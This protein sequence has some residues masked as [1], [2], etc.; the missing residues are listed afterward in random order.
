MA[1]SNSRRAPSTLLSTGSSVMDWWWASGEAAKSGQSRRY[2]HITPLG[3]ERLDCLR[4]EWDLFTEA[5]NRI[6]HSAGVR[7]NGVLVGT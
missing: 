4:R 2:Y 5:V 6:A 1:T 3:S 7:S